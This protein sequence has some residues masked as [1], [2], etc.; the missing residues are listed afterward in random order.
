[1]SRVEEES[2]RYLGCLGLLAE[3]AVYVP[4]DLREQIEAAMDDAC[5]ANPSLYWRR[6]LN[7]IEIG[8]RRE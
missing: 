6:I 8:V 5:A 2:T 7:R 4:D 1:M 3:C